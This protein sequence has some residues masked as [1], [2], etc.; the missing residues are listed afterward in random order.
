[1]RSRLVPGTGP[2]GAPTWQYRVAG[3][4]EAAIPIV[5]GQID[6]VNAD[7]TPPAKGKGEKR[8][9]GP[10]GVTNVEVVDDMTLAGMNVALPV[11]R[12]HLTS[13]HRLT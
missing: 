12:K 5:L 3:S 2:P 13:I 9:P 11:A 8:F 7:P 4:Y 10:A 6:G 1:M